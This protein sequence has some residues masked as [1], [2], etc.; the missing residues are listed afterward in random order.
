MGEKAMAKNKKWIQPRHKA[1]RTVLD[2]VLTPVMKHKYHA[3]LHK[4]NMQGRQFLVLFN[5]Q[6]AFDQFFVGS[7]F[8]R[9]PVY[10]IASEDVLNKGL[11]SKIIS[12]ATA[13]IPIKK[14]MTD[15]R[16]VMNCLRVVKEGGSV[17]LAPEGNRTYDG[18]LVHINPAVTK[19]V[20]TIGLP[21]AFC[22]IEGGY[23][24]QP[25]WSDVIRKGK[26]K[27]YV[28]KV[29]EKQDY[30][31]LSNEQLLELIT[32]NLDVNEG[33]ECGTFHSKRSAEYLERAYYVCPKCGLT[34]FHSKGQQFCC[35]KC[36]LQGTYT[37]TKRIVWSDESVDLPFT[38]HWY[39]YQQQFVQKLDVSPYLTTPIYQEQAT[40]FEV[41]PYKSRKVLDKRATL[42]LFADRVEVEGKN[43]CTLHF[44][45]VAVATVLGKN[46]L[47]FYVGKQVFQFKGDKRFN[48][49]KYVN[50]VYKH[51]NAKEE[52]DGTFLGI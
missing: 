12:Y 11:V 21:L 19:L 18:K 16:A 50:F 52:Q 13:P 41:V 43:P 22:R 23:G 31:D 6:T 42:K 35:T 7:V 28:S 9:G 2:V 26:I 40:M 8:C 46:K 34:T 39:D 1:W 24:V 38:T 51:K 32:Q 45:D 49:L 29:V 37:D 25:R 3:E 10:Y 44:D 20:K 4:F 36:G 5:H 30:Q 27:V 15:V 17:A 48:A 14:Q 47:N 33:V